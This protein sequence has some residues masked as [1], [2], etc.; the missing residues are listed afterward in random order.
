MTRSKNLGDKVLFSIHNNNQ[1]EVERYFIEYKHHMEITGKKFN[2]LK[3]KIYKAYCNYQRKKAKEFFQ[4][5]EDDV[6]F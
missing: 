6:R 2:S 5:N 3:D 4:S 1:E